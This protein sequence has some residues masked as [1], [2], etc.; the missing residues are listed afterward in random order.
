[1]EAMLHPADQKRGNDASSDHQKPLYGNLR[2]LWVPGRGGSSWIRGHLLNAQLGGPNTSPNLFPITQAA[3]KE[4][5]LYAENHVKKHIFE[6]KKVEYKVTATQGGGT[7]NHKGFQIP[8]AAAEFHC[9]ITPEG[10][11][12]YT[13]TIRSVPQLNTGAALLGVYASHSSESG[14]VK[15]V[16]RNSQLEEIGWGGDAPM[17]KS[18]VAKWEAEKREK[19]PQEIPMDIEGEEPDAEISGSGQAEDQ[20]TSEDE[21]L[22]MVAEN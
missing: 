20:L 5:L 13:S 14:K 12:K 19:T 9:E 10:G 8:N 6:G 3:N 7:I 4:H 15:G 17:G 21:Q 16:P 11:A 2:T 22:N 1:M 18:A